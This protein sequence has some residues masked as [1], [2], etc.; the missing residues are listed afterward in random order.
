MDT[1]SIAARAPEQERRL[2]NPSNADIN[3]MLEECYT[4][5]GS[6][7]VDMNGAKACRVYWPSTMSAN[8]VKKKQTVKTKLSQKSIEPKKATRESHKNPERVLA[9]TSQAPVIDKRSTLEVPRTSTSI[10]DIGRD[11]PGVQ[12][13]GVQPLK[14]ETEPA[15]VTRHLQKEEYECSSLPAKYQALQK[16]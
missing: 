6:G 11:R 13:P 8:Q 16:E 7:K 2:R 9:S 3:K 15:L 5:L 1:T 14:F 10:P 4:F 12:V